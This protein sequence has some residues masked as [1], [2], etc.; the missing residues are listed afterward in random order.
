MSVGDT[1]DS[2]EFAIESL[3]MRGPRRA[4]TALAELAAEAGLEV[5]LVHYPPG[6]SKWNKIDDACSPSSP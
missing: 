1:A 5:T 4:Q 2:A 6:T 3:R